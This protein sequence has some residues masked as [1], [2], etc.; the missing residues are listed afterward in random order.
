VDRRRNDIFLSFQFPAPSF[1]LSVLICQLFALSWLAVASIRAQ[2]LV[3]VAPDAAKVLYEDARV[4]VVRLTMAPNTS[5]PMHDRPRRVVIPLTGNDVTIT[6]PDG[7]V[8]STKTDALRPAWSE[9]GRRAVTNRDSRLENIIV[10]LKAADA[11]GVAAQ[12]PPTPPPAEYLADG[13]H[14]WLFENQYVRVYDVRIPPGEMTE[15]HRHGYDAVAVRASGGRVSTQLEGAQWS[16]PTEIEPG[17]VV[18]DADS[19]KP[20]V[21][22]V[23]NDGTSEYHLILVQLLR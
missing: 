7:T 1:R 19:K 23:R 15:F 10:E 9:P 22:R 6:R 11:P 13:R 2:D 16:A 5:S 8:G 17:S 20:F 18:F 12:Q 3:A 21:H 4:R 14:R